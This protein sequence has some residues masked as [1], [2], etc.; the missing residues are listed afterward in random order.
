MHI[1]EYKEFYKKNKR[2]CYLDNSAYEYQFIEGGFNLD[3]YIDIIN[4]I[5]PSH[6]I[7]PDV[8]ADY[9]ATINEFINFPLERI[10]K[11]VKTIGVVQGKNLEELERCF[12]FMNENV[13]MVALVFHSPAYEKNI[14]Y[15]DLDNAHGRYNF[16]NKIKHKIK[17]PIHLLGCSLPQEFT[18]Y[19]PEE[20]YSIDTANPVQFGMLDESYPDDFVFYNKPKL[21]LDEKNIIKEINNKD[22]II[23]NIREFRNNII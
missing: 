20:I 23:N 17:K 11:P 2:I 14:L 9:E 10:N 8:I 6:I 16:F 3:Y 19:K 1:P 22:I 5:E 18:W 15:R 13:D 4:E 12:D 7:I 21:I